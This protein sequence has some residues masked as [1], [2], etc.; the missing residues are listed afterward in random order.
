[1]TSSIPPTGSLAESDITLAGPSAA[2][3]TSASVFESVPSG[4]SAWMVTVPAEAT[5]EALIVAEQTDELAQVVAREEPF[6]RIVVP[7]PGL[8]G[9][10]TYP[11]I[12]SVNPFAAPAVTLAGAIPLMATADVSAT[13]ADAD[14]VESSW[15]VA[16]TVIEF[17]VGAAAGAVYTP[18]DVILPHALVAA[19][20][21][22]QF[23]P[24]FVVAETTAANS[25]VPEGATTEFA[26]ESRTLGCATTLISPVALRD[27]SAA[28]VAVTYTPAGLG[29]LPAPDNPPARPPLR[30]A[31]SMDWIRKDKSAPA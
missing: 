14:C 13:V 9:T 26:G 31:A 17:G 18:L 30:W 5:S 10:K 20:E 21:T 24:V 2:T 16:V 25:T 22:C 4:F 15:L 7:G 8:V 12:A 23:T 19:Q 3:T 27:V 1:V 6:T 11:L 29:T 28:A